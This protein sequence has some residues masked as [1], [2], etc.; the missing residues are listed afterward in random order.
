MTASDEAHN[1]PRTLKARVHQETA[2]LDQHVAASRKALLQHHIFLSG[3]LDNAFAAVRVTDAQGRYLFVNQCWLT[4]F[5]RTYDEVIGKT[6]AELFP[7]EQSPDTHNGQRRVEAESAWIQFQK[8]GVAD[9]LPEM[10][11]S[12]RIVLHDPQSEGDSLCDMVIDLS[13]QRHIEQ[14]LRESEE[15][16][17]R[18]F[19][20]VPVGLYR[21]TPD[22]AILDINLAAVEMLGYPDRAA[23][24]AA[25]AIEFY[26]DPADRRRWQKLLAHEGVVRKFEIQMRRQDGRTIWV[27]DNVRSIRDS[28]G[29]IVAYEGSLEDITDRK[30]AEDA[31]RESEEH[32]RAAAE[33][34][35]DAFFLLRSIRDQEGH[36]YDFTLAYM[37]RRAEALLGLPRE[38]LQHRRIRPLLPTYWSQQM[39]ERYREVLET[40]APLDEEVEIPTTGHGPRWYQH[41][42]IALHEGLAV[43]VRDMSERK[44]HE[45]EIEHL[46]FTDPLTGLPNRRRLYQ[47]GE[48]LVATAQAANQDIA[49]LY[50]DL[51]RFKAFNDTLGH[52]VGDELLVQV[53]R[54]LS[55]A[56]R[57]ETLLARIGGDEFAVL[58]TNTNAEQAQTVAQRLLARLCQPFKLRGQAVY[59]AGSIGIA[60]GPHEEL[61]FSTLLTRADIAMYRAKG[62]G[63]GIEV[64]DPSYSPLLP[65]QL[66]LETELRWALTTDGLVL[67][68]QPVLALDSNQIIGV[69]ALLR[70]PHPTR[71]TIMPNSFLPLAEESGLMRILD[72]WVIGKALEQASRWAEAGYVLDVA[73]NLTAYSLQN[74]DL[75]N[76]VN[77]LLTLTDVKPECIILEITE[78]T[79]LHDLHTTQ[80]VLTGLRDLGIRIALDDFGNGYAS[81]TYLQQMPI[82]IL[83]IDRAFTAGLG[84]QPRDEAVV[85]SLLA[86]GV[87]MDLTVIVEGVENTEQL[88]WLRRAGATLV[89]GY[90]IGPPV[91]PE[92][93]GEG[94]PLAPK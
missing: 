88:E 72:S 70:W 4:L 59:L 18:L 1:T 10:R 36:I 31:L 26:A 60:I 30:H 78:H 32:F 14:A 39:Y 52:D 44:A 71:G 68:Y 79:A 67:N 86:L 80:Q 75:V 37:N 9:T 33:G 21:T 92:H 73:I 49:L 29:N 54:R 7:A 15:E 65:D 53:T 19:D 91:L 61:T 13:K 38:E 84:Q 94:Y 83:K 82:D 24:L 93:L 42:A 5:R 41:Q 22:G 89:Q 16:Y 25:N 74:A 63:A 12:A 50:L 40:Q 66:Q 55:D 45:A 11:L 51:D 34:S 81:L 90:L 62:T 57:D 35:L 69:E 46:A 28:N 58:L 8:T 17:R 2:E 85:Q 6:D 3:I 76:E 64:Y 56:I 47:V 48:T 77:E 43:S 20:L 87:G 23:A 27:L